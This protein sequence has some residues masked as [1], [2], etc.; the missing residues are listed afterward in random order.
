MILKKLSYNFW[1]NK[2]MNIYK[3]IILFIALISYSSVI[4]GDTIKETTTYETKIYKSKTYEA[5]IYKA[6]VYEI[7][8]L[9]NTLN[10]NIIPEYISYEVYT[11]EDLEKKIENKEYSADFWQDIDWKPILTKL[12]VGTS[13]IL[14]TGALSVATMGATIGAPLLLHTVCL[15][16]FTGALKG[17]LI[18]TPTGAAINSAIQ[19][20]LNG[21]KIDGWQKYAIEGAAD[22]FIWS[23]TTGAILGTA[24]AYKDIPQIPNTAKNPTVK[25]ASEIVEYNGKV[26]KG[27]F[28]V[29]QSFFDVKLPKN[30][31][32][33]S[34]VEQ[35]KYAVN[36]LQSKLKN[37]IFRK[38]FIAKYGKKT[39][40]AIENS[41]NGRID[42]FTWH[43]HQKEGVLQLVDRVIHNNSG[44]SH[45]G[46]RAIWGGGSSYR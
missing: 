14:I 17:G 13:V 6:A 1:G 18:G 38:K 28:P 23:A 21:G 26:V 2:L 12:A 8:I 40:E 32:K 24:K 41:R 39:V 45:I 15:S 11:K 16:S 20:V 37:P 36:I 10:E 19:I 5:K 22:G 9:E 31:L 44:N 33:A 34:D 42:G 35:F 30:L 43:H 46:G 27:K 29:F 4:F 7:E 25:Y 3:R